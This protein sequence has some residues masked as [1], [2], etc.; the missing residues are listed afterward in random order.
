[1]L[2][3]CA[4]KDAPPEPAVTTAEQ[5][6][7]RRLDDTGLKAFL[8][9]VDAA[10]KAQG[11]DFKSLYWAA[12]YFNPDLRLARA[13]IAV[14]K[15][16]A[17]TAVQV[18]NPIL[19][20]P[21]TRDTTTTPHEWLIGVGLT[22]RI[23]T[24]GKRGIRQA[25]SDKQ[26]ASAQFS[27]INKA[28]E[29]RGA[30][31]NALLAL[32]DA[33]EALALSE[34]LAATEKS[35]V[36]EYDERLQQGQMPTAVA[37]QAQ[38]VYQQAVLQVQ[39]S[40]SAETDAKLQLAAALGVPLTAL[41]GIRIR[42]DTLKLG[43]P[44][45]MDEVEKAV[46]LK[47]HPALLAALADY[48]AAQNGVQLELANRV[49]DI[50]IGPGYQ[51]D[52]HQGG[53]FALNLTLNLPLFNDNEGPIAEA[54]AKRLVAARQLEAT[55]ASLLNAIEQAE[56]A[57]R[58]ARREWN[59]AT[60]IVQFQAAKL[61]RQRELLHGTEISIL[62]TLYGNAELQNAQ[63]AQHAAE[64]KWRKARASRETATRTALFGPVVN[65][66]SVTQTKGE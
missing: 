23:E 1:M 51:W 47:H 29:V 46:L 19:T 62:P 13:Q 16:A 48:E 18:P 33:R 4:L 57:D 10:P 25:I 24:N 38:V 64:S 60:G 7:S 28:W 15:A 20:L 11:W 21:L 3:G 58:N 50:E 12:V 55:Q 22:Q 14:P 66:T 61:K 17:V 34:R 53:I 27:A 32:A 39:Q 6:L 5:L 37:S 44:S 42:T 2:A 49:P 59:V 45:V 56:T 54:N 41:E 65:A 8:T 40:R 26:I 31:L 35:I 30:V 52:S 36:G 43:K 9:S 63:I